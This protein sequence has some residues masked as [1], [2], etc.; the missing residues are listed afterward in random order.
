MSDYETLHVRVADLV[1]W[2][3][4]DRPERRNAVDPA[5]ADQLLEAYRMF[6]ADD[7]ARVLI[8]TGAG[9]EYCTFEGGAG[10]RRLWA[11]GLILGGVVMLIVASSVR[12][13][14]STVSTTAD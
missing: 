4:I 3:T 13:E 2:L 7:D 6:E 1:A 8:L 11:I 14:R 9:E 5:T 10:G 12:T